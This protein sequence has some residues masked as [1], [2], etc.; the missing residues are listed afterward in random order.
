MPIRETPNTGMCYERALPALI[1]KAFHLRNVV[2]SLYSYFN[3]TNITDLNSYRVRQ[4]KKIS[5]MINTFIG[6]VGHRT[7]VVST[8]IL[9]RCIADSVVV[10]HLLYD[11]DNPEYV[12]LRH[13]LYILDG[14]N[15]RNDAVGDLKIEQYPETIREGVASLYAQ[16]KKNYEETKSLCEEKIKH[17]TLYQ[18]YRDEID[19]L[20]K[21]RMWKFQQISKPNEIVNWSTLYAKSDKLAPPEYTSYLSEDIHGLSFSVENIEPTPQSFTSSVMY[22]GYVCQWLVDY[23]DRRMSSLWN[24]KVQEYYDKITA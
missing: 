1:S 24:S 23:M 19:E 13:Y 7:D 18:T 12:Q 3:S 20:I 17:L 6:V 16:S 2:D 8:N 5:L 10:F 11:N 21:K 15:D 4:L 9:Q 22:V 14:N